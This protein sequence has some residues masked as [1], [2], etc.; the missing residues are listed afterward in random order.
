MCLTINEKLTD[1]IQEALDDQGYIAAYKV[2]V[3]SVETVNYGTSYHL[4]TKQKVNEVRDAPVSLFSLYQAHRW[5]VG[6]N[7]SDRRT[8]DVEDGIDEIHL[9]M[10]VFLYRKDAQE[11]ADTSGK[12]VIVTVKCNKDDFVKAGADGSKRD[13]AVFTKV[14]LTDFNRKLAVDD[15]KQKMMNILMNTQGI[16]YDM[17]D[18]TIAKI[19]L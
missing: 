17:I 18:P 10:H 7:V 19:D 8:T 12:R 16:V 13:C 6:L 5:N 15:A 1:E 4:S 3:S 9:G 11:Y 14:E 2:L